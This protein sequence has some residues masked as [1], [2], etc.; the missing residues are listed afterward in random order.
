M[1]P[2]A[3]TSS[4]S[5]AS[6][7]QKTAAG[8][9]RTFSDL[10]PP[11]FLLLQML[12]FTQHP[13]LLLSNLALPFWVALLQQSAPRADSTSSS[14]PHAPLPLDAAAAL[15]D[16]AG[17]PHARQITSSPRPPPLL[18]ASTPAGKRHY[19]LYTLGFV[20]E[21]AINISEVCANL[22]QAGNSPKPSP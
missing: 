21:D 5:R 16:L 19:I 14:K 6:A 7:Q 9:V 20:T 1:E 10:K 4:I 15:I 17:E 22:G 8:G 3:H 18:P 13:Y 12:G 2:P 11:A